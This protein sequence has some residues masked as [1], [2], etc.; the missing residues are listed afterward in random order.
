MSSVRARCGGTVSASSEV[1]EPAV[2]A[3]HSVTHQLLQPTPFG[4]SGLPRA[5]TNTISRFCSH[6]SPSTVSKRI[7]HITRLSSRICAE[8]VN[9]ISILSLRPYS[10]S[11]S[12]LLPWSSS[13]SRWPQP[14]PWYT[15]T[16]LPAAKLNGFPRAPRWVA[17]GDAFLACSF[18]L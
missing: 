3:Q 9:S 14:L 6:S 8:P 18:P 11:S 2:N 12:P 16:S 17:C 4:R 7:Q 1:A 10:V 13:T 15:S 5:N